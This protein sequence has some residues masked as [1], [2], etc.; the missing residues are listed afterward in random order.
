MDHK[1][2]VATGQQA[3]LTCICCRAR[4]QDAASIAN[5][6]ETTLLFLD[7]ACSEKAQATNDSSGTTAV[8]A[9][10]SHQHLTVANIGD[11]QARVLMA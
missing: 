1:D 10:V 2:G 3:E 7:E 9:A 6:L 5:F 4:S 11:S 8:L